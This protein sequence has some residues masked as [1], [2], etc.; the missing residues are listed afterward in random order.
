MNDIKQFEQECVD[1]ITLQ[2]QDKA[3]SSAKDK[4]EE[5]IG[6]YN[7]TYH[8]NWQGMPILKMPQDIMMMQELIWQIKP[9]IIIETGVA[10]GGSIVFYAA[11]L[12]MLGN[13]GLAIGVDIDIRKHNRDRIE[14]HPMYKNIKL[15]EG[16]SV[17]DIVLDKIKSLIKPESVVLVSLDSCHTEDHVYNELIAY[18][19]LIKKDSYIVVED[20]II[21]FTGDDR[22]R[23]WSK[24]NNPMTAIERFLKENNR[25][26]ID[27]SINDKLLLTSS[28][29]GYL[30]CIK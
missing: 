14:N 26:I 30:K 11:M 19:P 16:S 12:E 21:E 23:P 8:F 4:F 7:Y 27:K 2:G 28:P 5:L 24:G 20:T 10:R 22:N 15:I 3:I 17:D 6:K 18:T 9:D 29:N 25:F 1:E 13:D